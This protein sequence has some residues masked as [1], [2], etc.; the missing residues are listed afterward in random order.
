MRWQTRSPNESTLTLPEAP[1]PLRVPRG[2]DRPFIL[3]GNRE[4]APDFARR[5]RLPG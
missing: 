1:V 2:I 4:I 3:R 5:A